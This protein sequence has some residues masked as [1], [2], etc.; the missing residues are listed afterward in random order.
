MLPWSFAEGAQP[1]EHTSVLVKMILVP[2]Q[3]FISA[4]RHTGAKESFVIP[5]LAGRRYFNSRLTWG[6]SVPAALCLT[7]K[8]LC[9]ITCSQG[10]FQTKM[11]NFVLLA[12]LS[13]RF[14]SF[15][16]ELTSPIPFLVPQLFLQ[17]LFQFISTTFK[18]V[19]ST[20]F[21]CVSSQS[22]WFVSHSQKNRTRWL[23]LWC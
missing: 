1:S 10:Y 3:S 13:H 12:C 22:F 11:L 9:C 2:A 19:L 8:L 16:L 6:G 21:G 15:P 4:A 14:M 23:R 17:W 7:G 18:S 5:G 20:D